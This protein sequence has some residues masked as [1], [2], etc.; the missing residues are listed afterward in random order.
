MH[1]FIVEKVAQLV[2]LLIYVFFKIPPKVNSH[3]IGENSPNLV[4]LPTIYLLPSFCWQAKK[5][6]GTTP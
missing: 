3:P 5:L 4:T 2:G 6:D 1:Y